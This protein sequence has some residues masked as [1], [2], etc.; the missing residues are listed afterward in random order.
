LNVDNQE[1]RMAALVRQVALVS[2]S[3]QISAGDVAKVSAAL[4]RQVT[5]DVAPIWDIS[6]TVD[7]FERLQDVP[8]GYWPIIIMDDIGTPGAA[9]VHE[10]KDGQPFAL[11][12]AGDLDTWSLTASHEAIEMLVDPSGNRVVPGDSPKNDQGRVTFL[13]EPCDPSEAADFGYSVNGILVSD[14]YTPRYFDPVAAS[15]V[16]YSYTGAIKEPH[17]VLFG[18][19]LSWKDSATDHWWQEIFFSGSE[20]SFRDIGPIDQRAGNLR[21]AIDRVTNSD[22]LKAVARG[23]NRAE[24]AGITAAI[25]ADAST[26]KAK[27][28]RQQIEHILDQSPKRLSE[29]GSMERRPARRPP[30]TSN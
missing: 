26:S 28:W 27:A 21:A 22:T 30:R 7:S 6:A 15:G 19:Y 4:Q 8:P 24:A 14:F 10:D 2:Q 29:P 9:G 16:R 17:Q 3:S 1:A 20:S 25:V 12:T 18:G 11:V 23:R 5:R 13:V